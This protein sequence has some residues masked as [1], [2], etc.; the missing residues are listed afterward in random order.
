MTISLSIYT[1]IYIYIYIYYPVVNI[2]G[3]VWQIRKQV[4]LSAYDP[5]FHIYAQSTY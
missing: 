1:Y 4:P 3:V 2:V 5:G